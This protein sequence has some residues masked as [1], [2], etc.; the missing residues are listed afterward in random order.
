MAEI[1][2][3]TNTIEDIS[4]DDKN[5]Q[6]VLTMSPLENLESKINSLISGTPTVGSEAENFKRL[7]QATTPN[8][9]IVQVRVT[10]NFTL[11]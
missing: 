9:E 3:V 2:I 6:V 10:F 8:G 4:G 1:Q 7:Y 11:L 5:A